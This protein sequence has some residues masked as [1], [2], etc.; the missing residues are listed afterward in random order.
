VLFDYRPP[1]GVDNTRSSGVRVGNWLTPEQAKDLLLA[2][3]ENALKGKR[4]GA[5]LGLLV[6]CGLRRAR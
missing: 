6:G 1:A 5:L 3:E 2:P 4:D